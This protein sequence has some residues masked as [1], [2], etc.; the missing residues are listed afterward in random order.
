MITKQQLDMV[1]LLL[2]A[3]AKNIAEQTGLESLKCGRCTYDRAGNFTMK[4][5]GIN[6]GGKSAEAARYERNQHYLELPE[7]G[8]TFMNKDRTFRIVGLNTTGSKIIAADTAT[9]KQYLFKLE[10]IQRLAKQAA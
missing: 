9:N 5:E 10:Y 3:A 1:R 6:T 4:V 2:D 7:L 8:R